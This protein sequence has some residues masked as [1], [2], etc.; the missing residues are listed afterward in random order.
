MAVLSNTG[1]PIVP[2]VGAETVVATI[3]PGA[4]LDNITVYVTGGT[5]GGGGQLEFALYA[6]VGG[7]QTRIAQKQIVGSNTPSIIDWDTGIGPLDGGGGKRAQ[8]E[9]VDAGGTN[10]T[11]T[12]I[13]LSAGLP[14]PGAATRQ[15][16]TVTIAGVATFDTVADQNFGALLGPI[17]PGA[18]AFLSTF[19]GYAQF[20]DVAIDQTNLPPVTVTLAA[21]C[22][23]GS[24]QAVVESENLTGVDSDIAAVFRKVRLPVATRYFV[25][26]TNNSQVA[27]SVTLTGVTYSLVP[28]TAGGVVTLGGDVIGPSNANT[29]IKWDN[30]PLTL[31]GSG[32][33]GA[34][35]DAALPI[36]DIG[37]NTWRA[38]A[39]SGG[40]TMTNAGVV[41]INAASITLGGD[42]TGPANAN[43]VIKWDSVPL[44]LGAAPGFTTPVDAAIPIYD[45][46]TNTWRTFALSGGATM[47]DGGVVTIGGASVTLTGN[48]V[49]PGNANH[50]QTFG[51][52]S[53][54][55]SV[56]AA[57]FTPITAGLWY[58][59]IS[60]LTGNITVTLP[61]T[62]PSGSQVIVKDED[63]S[64]GDGFTITVEGSIGKTIDGNATFVMGNPNPGPKGSNTFL[65]NFNATTE[66]V[67]T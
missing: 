45:I 16:V 26:V 54:N 44:E 36:Y 8:N 32:T 56:P 63:G 6:E 14:A 3:A 60:G 28:A 19:N 31:A 20:M 47:T 64:I 49:G 7:F 9:L 53:V 40:A 13:D 17:A 18:T 50:L 33:F 15:A 42:V 2:V 67:V 52:E 65:M 34:P 37:T 43:T 38:L 62:M 46:G 24:V 27:L 66:W 21:D 61:D 11:V 51:I 59:G 23:G 5:G 30:V 55:A 48:T 12:V 10:Y 1:A 57:S 41:T 58:V 39:L 25:S 35:V 4:P 22:G 29:V